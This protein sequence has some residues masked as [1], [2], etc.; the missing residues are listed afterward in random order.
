MDRVVAAVVVN[1]IL[2]EDSDNNCCLLDFSSL[3][4]CII[5]SA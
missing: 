2:W 5:D 1:G 3:R 4:L